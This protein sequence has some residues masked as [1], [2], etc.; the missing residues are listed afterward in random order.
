MLYVE[1]KTQQAERVLN[2]LLNKAKTSAFLSVNK[3]TE[4]GF[5]YARA[6]APANSGFTFSSIHK[7]IKRTKDGV[8]GKLYINPVITPDSERVFG[9]GTRAE[10]FSLVKWMHQTKGRFQTDN[11]FG[12][13]GT[14]HI[15]V[16]KATFMYGARDLMR[17]V[18]GNVA[19]G[20]YKSMM[21]K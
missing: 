12:R 20:T 16:K 15:P 11:P 9:P 10:P 19:R 13:A 4:I 1:L 21:V 3:I 2:K 8:V 17:K 7:S 14:Q 18:G 5:N 6:T